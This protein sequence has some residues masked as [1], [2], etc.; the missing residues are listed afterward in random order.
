MVL[1]SSPEISSSPSPFK[2]PRG[3]VNDTRHISHSITK[4]Q[5]S[6]SLLGKLGKIKSFFVE[7]ASFSTNTHKLNNSKRYDKVR[8]RSNSRQVMCNTPY[9]QLSKSQQLYD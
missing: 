2:V 3:G 6:K 8:G 5:D 9:K 4:N 1:V 7:S